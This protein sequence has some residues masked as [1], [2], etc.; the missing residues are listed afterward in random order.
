[1]LDWAAGILLNI[2]KRALSLYSS[3]FI[4]SCRQL[5]YCHLSSCCPWDPAEYCDHDMHEAEQILS[6]YKITWFPGFPFTE[7]EFIVHYITVFIYVTQRTSPEWY[8]DVGVRMMAHLLVPFLCCTI[9]GQRMAVPP[10]KK[11]ISSLLSFC[12]IFSPSQQ[13]KPVNHF[14]R[15][16]NICRRLGRLLSMS[17]SSESFS[18][19]T[20][21]NTCGIKIFSCR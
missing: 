19:C 12:H 4:K 3:D 13:H 2:L 16:G 18:D 21:I 8:K 7:R 1:M 20:V 5:N 14:L 9:T 6:N 11:G 17:C 10:W 15:R